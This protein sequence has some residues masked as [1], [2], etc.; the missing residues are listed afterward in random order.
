MQ[1]GL[2][3]MAERK[4][5]AAVLEFKNAVQLDPNDAQAHYQLGLAHLQMT[6]EHRDRGA[7][8]DLRAAF[9]ALNRSV[10]LDTKN[11]DAQLKLGE[12]Y[13][14]AKDATEAQAKAEFVLKNA[15]DNEVPSLAAAHYYL[16]VA[17]VYNQKPRMAKAAFDT[18]I[19]LWPQF[20]A[21]SMALLKLHMQEHAFSEAIEAGKKVLQLQP[22]NV[23]AH[24][25]THLRRDTVIP[26]WF[27]ASKAAAASDGHAVHY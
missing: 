15:A 24:M 4:Y 16:G 6:A 9:R 12:L 18:A 25:G 17:Q 10:Q 1:K 23:E 27:Q 21:A 26:Q 22:N 11:I 3:Y 13:L 5:P 14:L 7:L 20:P 19:K 8:T 2:A